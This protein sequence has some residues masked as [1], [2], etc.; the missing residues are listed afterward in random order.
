MT[1]WA[2][3]SGPRGGSSPA[4][5]RPGPTLSG[6]P[7][8]P[9]GLRRGRGGVVIVD[10]ICVRRAPPDRPTITCRRPGNG[11]YRPID[12]VPGPASFWL[13]WSASFPARTSP[14]APKGRT[15]PASGPPLPAPSKAHHPGHRATR[16]GPALIVVLK[17]RALRALLHPPR[18]PF[19]AVKDPPTSGSL[20]PPRPHPTHRA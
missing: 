8:D 14:G 18:A 10:D 11:R 15:P 6:G 4:L 13:T 16:P 1:S 20:H 9:L 17:G 5:L 2:A 7:S 12:P 19:A 3:I